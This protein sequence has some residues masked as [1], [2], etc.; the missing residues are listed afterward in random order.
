M[1]GDQGLLSVLQARHARAGA[2]VASGLWRPHPA[3]A[4]DASVGAVVVTVRRG[5]EGAREMVKLNGKGHQSWCLRRPRW[6]HQVEGQAL[7][8][9][10]VTK[11][12]CLWGREGQREGARL[13]LVLG[14]M[15][16]TYFWT[17]CDSMGVYF[18][19]NPR[20]VRLFCTPIPLHN[21]LCWKTRK[22]K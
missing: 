20:A 10:N 5:R 12:G 2:S 1:C 7:T 17:R 4:L 21:G 18:V 19:T 22:R 13:A 15:M 9:L 14:N 3:S 8:A 6:G 16:V 11:S